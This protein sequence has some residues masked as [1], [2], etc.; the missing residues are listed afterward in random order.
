MI[1]KNG[2]FITHNKNWIGDLRE[3]DGIIVELGTNIEPSPGE[4]VIDAKGNIVIPGGIDVHTHLS[5]DVGIAVA[6][7]D[8][9]TGTVAAACG[10]TTTIVDHIGFGPTNCNLDY[11]INK[12][13]TLAKD[14]AV[15]DYSFHGVIQHVDNNVL[16]LMEKLIEKG[17][18][19]YKFYLTYDY[20]LSDEDCFKILKKSK[21]LGLVITV[22]PEND[23]VINYLK[24]KNQSDGN[25]S[26]EYHGKS[27]PIECEAE[28]INRMLLFSKICGD[29]P[30][31]IVH[32]S[33]GLGLDYIKFARDHGQKNI[34]AET[35]P[36]YLF[37]DESRYLDDDGLKYI[38]S[39]PLR[40]KENNQLL[41]QGIKENHIDTIATDHCPF[42][43]YREKQ[44]G[45]KNFAKCPN[46]APGIEAR[47]PLL[48]DKC[49]KE[50]ISLN[51][52]VDMCSTK[53]AKIFGMYPEKG[54]I[55][56]GSHCDLAI[57]DPN[58]KKV[59][60]HEI[61]H[62]NVDYTPYEGIEVN[63]YPIMTISK[64]NVIVEYGKFLGKKGSGSF[65]K[66]KVYDHTL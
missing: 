27:R 2:N 17:I 30:I 19:S 15:I 66:R 8:F 3:K 12:Y 64:G 46:G 5:L 28:A 34:F 26:P 39:P 9:Y 13:H 41:L 55:E 61:L 50:N 18:T 53:P 10:G 63:G 32:L 7:D 24:E 31:Y 43:Y 52:F 29:T 57:I 62:E 11:Q 38:M 45:V 40:D 44:M 42:N 1:I 25:F 20:K 58:V 49:V 36:Q 47:I 4:N 21:E 59:I 56:I 51:K 16:E 22:H 6:T 35:C 60:S 54:A 37:L 48:Y 65:V 23:G 33:N 14:N